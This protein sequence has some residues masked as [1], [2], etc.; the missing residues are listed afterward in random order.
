MRL[1]LALLVFLALIGPVAA[2]SFI[3]AREV[4]EINGRTRKSVLNGII[5]DGTGMTF[6]SREDL[7]AFA[8]SRTQKLENLRVFTESRVSVTYP[9]D[10]LLAGNGENPVP[11]TIRVLIEDGTPVSPVPFAFYNSNDGFQSG[12]LV[13]VPN[14]AGSLQNLMLMGLYIAPPD[15]N[16]RLEWSNPNY[17]FLCVWNGIRIDRLKLSVSGNVMKME[18]DVTDRGVT[19]LTYDALQ[20]A[21]TAAL[22]CPLTDT[23]TDTLSLVVG[24]SPE[25][26]IVSVTDRELLSYGPLSNFWQIR[27]ELAWEDYDW[28]GN[29]RNGWQASA[30]IGYT[31]YHPHY[32]EAL[33]EIRAEAK[34]VGYYV[35]N[36]RFN[37]SFQ[38]RTFAKT[39]QSEL[40]TGYNVRGIRNDSMKGTSGVFVNSGV[41]TKLCRFGEAELHLTPSVDFGWAY[42]EDENDYKNDWGF[43]AGG[44]MVLV[45][46]SMKTLPIK[47]GMYC[48]L[49]P[50]NRIGDGKRLEV[51]F[52][53]SF[54]Y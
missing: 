50:E 18:R 41:Q 20:F 38:V 31:S 42:A 24:G 29:F 15:E 11:V 40:D 34:L 43:G 32:E 19:G 22:A 52:N 33:D 35:L 17:M 1:T 4:Y 36:D 27:D 54:S 8:E 6:A 37:P 48:D 2:E 7:E 13:N 28:I 16:D 47:L 44:E 26:S 14:V 21:G 45:F 25:S 9:E 39:G 51:D 30:T 53:F 49:R 23:V 3:V 10:T 12:L 5:G 46:D